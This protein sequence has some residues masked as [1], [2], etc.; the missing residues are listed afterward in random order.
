MKFIK[1]AL[2]ALVA[3]I[4]LYIVYAIYVSDSSVVTGAGFGITVTFILSVIAAGAA[5]VFPIISMISHP[6]SAIRA[7][8]G[9]GLIVVVFLI[10]YLVAGNEILISYER[11]GFTSPSASKMVGGALNMMYMAIVAVL[12]VTIYAEVKNLMK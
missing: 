5:I 1:P 12:G 3:L 9:V 6:K 10:G 2:Y 4:C 11:V 7:L 8:I